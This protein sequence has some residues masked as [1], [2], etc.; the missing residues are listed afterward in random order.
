[1]GGARA[2]LGN[3]GVLCSFLP[4]ANLIC[5]CWSRLSARWT[6]KKKKRKKHEIFSFQKCWETVSTA[7]DS[8]PTFRVCPTLKKKEKKVKS[9]DRKLV[10]RQQRRRAVTP[11][12]RFY[13]TG[14]IF[15]IKKPWLN[16]YS[17]LEA[18]P[19]WSQSKAA[20]SPQ[21]RL[22]LDFWINLRAKRP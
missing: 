19:V 9:A 12:P 7:T 21:S 8:S 18:L 14:E 10:R 2:H 5:C 22:S 13:L 20:V 15:N 6:P 11:Q 17:G 4:H 1:M 3:G 16:I